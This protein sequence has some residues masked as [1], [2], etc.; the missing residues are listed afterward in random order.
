A[1]FF[2]FTGYVIIAAAL[3]MMGNSFVFILGKLQKPMPMTMPVTELFYITPFFWLLLLLTTPVITMR[4]F[5][6]EKFSGT[7]ETLMTTP[8]SDVQVVG[9]KFTG[10]VFFYM[11]MWL[12]LLGCIL[13][14]RHYTSDPAAFDAEIV[15]STF[16]GIF[17]L[18]CVF[19]S[20]GCFASALTRSQ[21]TAAM[22]GLLLCFSL[23]LLS[24]LADRLPG[25]DWQAQALSMFALPEQ[26]HDFVRGVVDTRP[27]ILYLSLTFFFLF[28]TLRVLGSRR[29]K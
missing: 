19:I 18:G 6:L 23:F 3:L 15:G 28:L 8:I 10:A 14:V 13:I 17:L 9:A 29:W 27:V 16:L 2:S 20:L 22:I 4:L 1:F 25:P 12:P 7:F 21:M 24:F 11:I 5:A 26:M